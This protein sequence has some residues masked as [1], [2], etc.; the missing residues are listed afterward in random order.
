[1]DVI[2][3]GGQYTQ[4]LNR[5]MSGKDTA[6]LD[7]GLC[8]RPSLASAGE[9]ILKLTSR[10]FLPIVDNGGEFVFRAFHL[11]PLRNEPLEVP[12]PRPSGL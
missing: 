4:L 11:H 1:M 3:A 9:Y 10:T 8:R 6:S 7:T 2:A 5:V 12:Q